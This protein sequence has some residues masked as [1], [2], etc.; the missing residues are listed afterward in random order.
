M[1]EVRVWMSRLG[2]MRRESVSEGGEK[3]GVLAK[4]GEVRG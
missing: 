4:A 1:S 2:A 3:K